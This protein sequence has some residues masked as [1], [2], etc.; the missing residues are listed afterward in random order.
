MVPDALRPHMDVRAFLFGRHGIFDRILD[1][2]LQQQRGDQR[3]AGGVFDIEIGTQPFLEP[4]LLDIQIQFQR[5]DFLGH[6]HARGGLVDQRE[7]Q[8]GRKAGQHGIG[9]LRL[10]QKHQRGNRIQRVEQEMR[11]ELVAQHGQLSAGGLRLQPKQLIGLLFGADIEVD[12][13]IQGRPCRERHAGQ[14]QRSGKDAGKAAFRHRRELKDP[15]IH[16]GID[17]DG[18]RQA[19]QHAAPDDQRP[20]IEHD[21]ID[22]RQDQRDRIA[23]DGG[24]QQRHQLVERHLIGNRR[25]RAKDQRTGPARAVQVPECPVLVRKERFDR[26]FDNRHPGNP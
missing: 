26:Q 1:K 10:L 25:T 21:A 18:H 2:R 11:V 15:G 13:K 17:H 14:Q 8:E 4:H 9:R 19:G 22:H 5:F 24:N 16:E 23:G 3:I 12:G 20:P 7:T 6:R